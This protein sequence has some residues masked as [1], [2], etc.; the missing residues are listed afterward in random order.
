MGGTGGGHVY[1][2]EELRQVAT[3]V[4]DQVQ[5]ASEIINRLRE[6]GRKPDFKKEPVNINTIISNVL[7]IIG[8]QLSLNNIHVAYDLAS[9]LPPILANP[10]RL[11]QVLFNLVTNARDA[12][13]Q[14]S[15]DADGHHAR[16]IIIETYVDKDDVVC[17]VADTGSGIPDENRDK[18]F[19]PFFTTK[20][21]GKGMGLGLAITYRIVREYGGNI[22]VRSK[23]GK[24]TRFEMRF[25]R[26]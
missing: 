5:R 4:T 3:A 17:A 23:V 26:T 16:E 18:I 25:R 21:V 22:T 8:N 14:R 1:N 9:R 20:E 13:G 2:V 12:I 24:G 7:K 15:G 10:N 19:E 6:F 11:E